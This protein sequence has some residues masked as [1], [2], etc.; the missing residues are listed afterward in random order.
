MGVVV[1]GDASVRPAVVRRRHHCA[2]ETGV[3]VGRSVRSE[4]A[5]RLPT[6]GS[7]APSWEAPVAVAVMTPR[8]GSVPA[9][10]C[11]HQPE[12]R[13]GG[14][15]PFVY[16]WR[17]IGGWPSSLRNGL[18]SFVGVGVVRRCRC[19]SSSAPARWR[20]PDSLRALHIDASSLRQG[21][22]RSREA[23]EWSG[24][25]RAGQGAVAVGGVH[26]SRRRALAAASSRRRAAGAMAK[27]I[28]PACGTKMNRILGTA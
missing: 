26:R 24:R 25:P 21:W 4:S 10:D 6:A 28:C 7:S 5:D 13:V 15:T 17:A 2:A 23:G 8:R 18:P 22:Q 12:V 27:G 14:E 9:H 11:G 3:Q 1:D 16:P 20:G 19:R